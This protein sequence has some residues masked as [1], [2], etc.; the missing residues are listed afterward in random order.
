MSDY[1]E[2]LCDHLCDQMVFPPEWRQRMEAYSA[3]HSRLDASMTSDQ[4]VVLEDLFNSYYEVARIER[5]LLFLQ[6]LSL[7]I[8]LGRL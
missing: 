8:D 4:R 1:L 6:A 5:Q 3:V 2:K 7:G